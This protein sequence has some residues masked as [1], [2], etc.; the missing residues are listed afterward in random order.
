MRAV[1]FHGRRERG[2][3]GDFLL[4]ARILGEA[5]LQTGRAAQ[6]RTAMWPASPGS[7]DRA[8]V[9]VDAQPLMDLN[10]PGRYHVEVVCDPLLA[11]IPPMGNALLPGGRLIVHASVP[12]EVPEGGPETVSADFAA[13]AGPAGAP[14]AVALAGGGWAAL[15][16]T[17]PELGL[18]RV[19]PLEACSEVLGPEAR[20]GWGKVLEDSAGLVRRALEKCTS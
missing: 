5:V 1:C 16:Q 13:L 4:A 7:P 15:A 20:E 9:R 10:V 18:P 3:S 12:P 14:L 8:I 11:V 17:A 6:V 2:G 19:P